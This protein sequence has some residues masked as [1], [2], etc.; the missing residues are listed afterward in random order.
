[1]ILQKILQGLRVAKAA[2]NERWLKKAEN[3]RSGS[4]AKD[5][6]KEEKK[7]QKFV[8]TMANRV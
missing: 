1:M 3:G 7:D 4:K 6:G 2:M 8:I 5:G